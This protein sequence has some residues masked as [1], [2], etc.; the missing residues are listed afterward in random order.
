M[1]IIKV[2]NIQP[3]SGNT[4][5]FTQGITI[6]NQLDIIGELDLS[7]GNLNIQSAKLDYHENLD[8]D[9]GTEVVA[10]IPTGSASAAFFDYAVTDGTNVRAGTVMTA[11]LGTTT[12]YADTSTADIG[13]TEDVDFTTSIS[14]SSVLLQVTTI[15]NN[16]SI[17]ALSRL[18]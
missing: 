12:T 17:K 4:V 5:S 9:T 1:S 14:G 7:A 11:W 18:L 3:F 16:W 2:D 10:T 6:Q 13:N 15:S 8:A